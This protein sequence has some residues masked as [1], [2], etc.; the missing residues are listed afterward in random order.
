MSRKPRTITRDQLAK[1][2]AITAGRVTPRQQPERAIQTAIMRLL[3]AHGFQVWSTSQGYRKERG[4]TRVTPGMPDLYAFHRGLALWV[5]VKAPGGTL[6]PAQEAFLREH[7]AYGDHAQCW[8]SVEG[9]QAW[10]TRVG[11]AAVDASRRRYLGE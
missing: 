8:S 1:A 9:C 3:T 2:D 5:E 7:A 10:L 6:R 11:F 4:G